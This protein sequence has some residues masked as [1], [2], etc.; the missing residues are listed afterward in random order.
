MLSEADEN[1]IWK[2]LRNGEEKRGRMDERIR[3]LFKS[4]KEI[5]ED[6][7]GIRR[8]LLVGILTFIAGFAGAFAAKFF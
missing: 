4:H 2:R 5:K 1:D 7:K 8:L 3:S 6:L